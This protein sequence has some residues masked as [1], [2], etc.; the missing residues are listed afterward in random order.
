MQAPRKFSFSIGGFGGFHHLDLL[1]DKTVRYRF[2][3][4]TPLEHDPTHLFSPSP[5]EWDMFREAMDE[6]GVWS[7]KEEYRP[8]NP[9]CDGAQWSL[10]L[11]WG[12]S[13]IRILGD[14]ARPDTF[15]QFVS[16]VEKLL[17]IDDLWSLSG[18]M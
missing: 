2:G 15:W 7:W 6:L 3:Y 13:R 10:W 16:A 11:T 5:G 8:E 12:K 17:E 4:D 18:R 1:P 9:F 14:N